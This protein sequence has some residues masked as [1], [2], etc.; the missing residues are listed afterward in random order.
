[1]AP[2]LDQELF[3]EIKEQLASIKQELS[4]F[5]A[6]IQVKMDTL[7]EKQDKMAKAQEK[8]D[9][10]LYTPT[11]GV[12]ARLQE[13]ESWKGSSSKIIWTIG[14]IVAGLIINQLYSMLI[15]G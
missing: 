3:S 1:M 9:N 2:N 14:S 8:V 5:M 15:S 6:T 13:L 11:T 4:S 10:E 7:I 12:F